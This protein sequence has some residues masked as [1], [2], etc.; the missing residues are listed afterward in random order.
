MSKEDR[1]R[2]QK[3]YFDLF[4]EFVYSK[5]I[6]NRIGTGIKPGSKKTQV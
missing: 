6:G 4:T 3:S 1:R 5:G 2:V